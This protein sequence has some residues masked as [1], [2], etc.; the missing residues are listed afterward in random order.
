MSIILKKVQLNERS[1]TEHPHVNMTQNKK[2]IILKGSN[3]KCPSHHYTLQRQLLSR[4]LNYTFVL[5]CLNLKCFY[6]S[7][8]LCFE[9]VLRS[10]YWKYSLW[11]C[12]V[13]RWDL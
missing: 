7:H 13:A 3:P 12:S 9:R 1:H 2:Q 10:S 6:S 11:C 8:L 4:L 5:L